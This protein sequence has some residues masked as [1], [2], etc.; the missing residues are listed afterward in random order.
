MEPPESLASI[1]EPSAATADQ[2]SRAHSVLLRRTMQSPITLAW[3]AYLRQACLTSSLRSS[4]KASI[5]S[6][7]RFPG[8]CPTNAQATAEPLPADGKATAKR[9]RS[10]FAR[11]SACP[12]PPLAG[13][14]RSEPRAPAA[15][16]FG[17]RLQ[18][19]VPEAENRHA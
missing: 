16:G 14:R 8:S 11:P 19:S 2:R 15:I 13:R 4:A 12:Q 5:P 1:S 6:L 10:A 7:S 3:P 17:R 9:D 18:K